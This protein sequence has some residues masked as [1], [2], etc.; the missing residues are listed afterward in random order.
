MKNRIAIVFL[1]AFMCP[2]V[3]AQT[4]IRGKVIDRD[5]K[6]P[7]AFANVVFDNNNQLHVIADM[8][9][10]FSFSSKI[11]V[12]TIQ[13]S[14]TGYEKYTTTLGNQD[15]LLIAMSSAVNELAEVTVDPNE[16]PAYAIMRKV[17][18]NKSR[19][20]PENLNTFK[21]TCY[22]KV[23]VDYLW[24]NA[25]NDSLYTNGKL[26]KNHLFLNESV[27]EKKYSRPNNSEEVIIATRVSGFENPTFASLAT[28][29]QPFSFYQDYIKLFDVR[30]LNPIANGRLKKYKF[31]LE[32]AV[33]KDQDSVFIIAFEP[34]K[35]TNFDGLS[36]LLYINSNGYA[37]QNV[38]ASP[39][40][41]GKIDIKIQQQYQFLE[42]KHWFPEQLNY[43][44][45][46]PEYPTKNL[47]LYAEGK[48]YINAVSFDIPL[49]KRDFSELNVRLA[50]NAATKDSAFWNQ[51]RNNPLTEY[52]RNTY[53]IVDSIG[54]AKNY[55]R[56]LI[57]AEKLFQGKL[58]LGFVD[59][60]LNKTLIYNQFEGLRLG[61]GLLTNETLSKRFM[62]GGFFGY[63]LKDEQFKY[64]GS[65]QYEIA[66]NHAVKI[67]LSYQNNLIEIGNYGLPSNEN[68]LFNLRNLIGSRFD[69]IQQ[70][71]VAFQF[72][73]LGF[74][75]WHVSFSQADITP[76]YQYAFQ[77]ADDRFTK[78]KNTELSVRLRYA[79]AEK[80]ISSFGTTFSGSTPYPIVSFL[81]TKGFKNLL[82]GN[83]NYVR[84]EAAFEQ[85]FY[86]KNFG[87]THYRVEG[88]YISKPLPLGMLFTGEGSNDAELPF[89][90]K[91]Y[92]QTMQPYEF[93]SDQYASLFI[94]H[95]FGTLLLKNKF[96]QPNIVLQHNM[97]WGQLSSENRHLY[98][99]FKNKENTYLESGIKLENLIKL[100]YLNLGYLGMGVGGYY[101]YGYYANADIEDNVAFKLTLNFTIK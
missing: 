101:R 55:D 39:F 26:K 93:L 21:Y 88:G 100:N 66:H 62:L 65:V 85:Q 29:L 25:K 78:Y 37:I 11:T 61:V 97:G 70:K 14:Y 54:K 20:N 49:T 87:N 9:G 68:R 28:D 17:I 84:L 46:M 2:F 51:Y 18:A 31:R 50:D 56:Y 45:S 38:I 7:L 89:V 73:N 72:K 86:I 48:S 42:G 22:N 47:G 30:Y 8:D 94:S 90:V 77:D 16:N 79:F 35:G 1:M 40:E 76:Q 60:D 80:Q 96:I 92:F 69:R 44:L 95:D 36:G 91:N 34:R 81:F 57:L 67:G 53:T 83:F 13:C 33:F 52:E 59:L 24:K 98:S 43:M 63:G 64:G 58:P 27:S 6:K 19:N 4:N 3:V 74:A 12:S 5:S 71:S 23:V 82:N 32:D 75:K 41:K 10:Q 15:D 99:D